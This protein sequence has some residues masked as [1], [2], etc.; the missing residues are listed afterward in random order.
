MTATL[1]PHAAG[2][3]FKFS[4]GSDK[5]LQIFVPIV[6]PFVAGDFVRELS[7]LL[8]DALARA[9]ESN[10]LFSEFEAEFV[11]QVFDATTQTEESK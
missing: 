5:P 2:V 7:S 1:V 11:P 9:D 10:S 4:D 3:F 8:G 6:K